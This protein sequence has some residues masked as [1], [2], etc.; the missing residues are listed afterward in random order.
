[1]KKTVFLRYGIIA[2]FLLAVILPGSPAVFAQD[3][4]S[5]D[6]GPVWHYL[7]AAFGLGMVAI[8]AAI[9]IGKASAA[10]A[11]S[12]ARQPSAASEITGAVN[13]PIFLMEGVFI[14]AEV[15]ILFIVFIT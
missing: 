9:G 5:A 12:I 3:G 15:L 6:T 13:L 7:A 10:A 11:E 1:M 2:A 14:L 4:A 8:A